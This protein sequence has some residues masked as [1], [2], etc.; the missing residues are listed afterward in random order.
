MF[1]GRGV[2]GSGGGD[3]R[4]AGWTYKTV[5]AAVNV[6]TGSSSTARRL[7]LGRF[8]LRLAKFRGAG[9]GA[10]MLSQWIA[11]GAACVRC[12]QPTKAIGPLE[13]AMAAAQRE[14]GADDPSTRSAR[15]QLITAYRKVGR[16][17][18]ATRLAQRA[19]RST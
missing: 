16:K 1:V 13:R 19:L 10:D 12:N 15:E 8:A 3:Y 11:L 6:P 9:D 4:A 18:D 5:M 17:T 7:A 14:F 2:V